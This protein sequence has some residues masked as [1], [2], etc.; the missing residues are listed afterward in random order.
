MYGEQSLRGEKLVKKKGDEKKKVMWQICKVVA[1]WK[2]SVLKL[3]CLT[4]VKDNG[5]NCFPN[6]GA[7]ISS[8]ASVSVSAISLFNYTISLQQG[9]CK[10]EWRKML[11]PCQSRRNKGFHCLNRS[12]NSIMNLDIQHSTHNF[13]TVICEDLERE[14]CLSHQLKLVYKCIY[15][16][17]VQYVRVCLCFSSKISPI[18]F[19]E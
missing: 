1:L 18:S 5:G 9:I 11:I 2:F 14:G 3:I 12:V 10:P 15:F 19:L 6:N 16:L 13:M 8:D 7:V 4:M 17:F